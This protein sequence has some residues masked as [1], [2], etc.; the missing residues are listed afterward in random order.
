MSKWTPDIVAF[1]CAQ[2]LDERKSAGEIAKALD[3]AF[4]RNAVTGKLLRVG[5][6][7]KRKGVELGKDHG[8]PRKP[9]APK[10]RA[11][12][13]VRGRRSAQLMIKAAPPP[14]VEPTPDLGAAD[15]KLVARAESLFEGPGIPLLETSSSHC[16]W[17]AKSEN[18]APHVCGLT[19]ARGAYCAF[20]ADIAYGPRRQRRLDA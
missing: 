12:K 3:Y 13:R 5:A 19:K 2:Y 10:A 17:P 20:H 9:P 4:S 18:G 6:L 14:P 11:E 16:R 1:I 15:L 8:L 7:G